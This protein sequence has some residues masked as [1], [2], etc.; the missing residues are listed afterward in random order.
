MEPRIVIKDEFMVVGLEYIGKNENREISQ[1]W[2]E[3][4][5]RISEIKN[6]NNPGIFYGVCE[7]TGDAATGFSYI[8]GQEVSDMDDIPEGMAG[9][10]IP[11]AKYAVYTHT[12]SFEALSTTYQNIF[13]TWLPQSGMEIAD[14]ITLELYDERFDNFSEKSAFDIYVP[15]K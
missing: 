12:G 3:L 10:V 15:I 11:A 7:C 1:M 2:G 14:G 5:P 4:F 13:Q 6:I 9:K 8:A